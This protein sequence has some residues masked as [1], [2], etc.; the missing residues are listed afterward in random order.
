MSYVNIAVIAA[1]AAILSK[2]FLKNIIRML[3]NSSRE[4]CSAVNYRGKTIPAIGGIAFIPIMLAGVLIL[5]VYDT[6]NSSV[7]LGY[8]ALV[9]SMGLSGVVDD[10]VGDTSTK[11]LVNHIR[12]TLRGRMTTGFLK[13]L[14]G[15]LVS[16][17]VSFGMSDTYAEFIVNVLI[18]SL[19]ANT[20]NL[21]DLRPGRAV[22][23]FLAVSFWLLTASLWRLADAMPVI[24]LD[25]AVLFYV[26]Y[27]LKEVCMLGD[28]GANVLGISLGYYCSLLLGFYGK[29][30]VLALL[31]AVNIISEKL[32]ISDLI[33][34]SRFFSYL[35][36][37]GREHAK[38]R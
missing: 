14:I 1:V 25:I 4:T 2:F 28:T 6:N 35:D 27:D 7:Y 36:N 33:N 3:C 9:L 24:I 30:S 15:F 31:I 5:L 37:L 34:R 22:K 26:R 11:G 16:S 8:L 17:I 23:V 12:S 18:I 13:A 10:L 20:M 29:L 32:S 21:F 38:G 19:F